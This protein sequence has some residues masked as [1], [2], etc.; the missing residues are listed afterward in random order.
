MFNGNQDTLFQ[1]PLSG[2]F[3]IAPFIWNGIWTIINVVDF[4]VLYE[5]LL[6]Q[7]NNVFLENITD[8]KI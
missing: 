4:A 7:N 8:P 1:D 5:S 2:K 6:N 3:K